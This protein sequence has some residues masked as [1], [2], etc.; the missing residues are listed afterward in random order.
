MSDPKPPLKS[1]RLLDDFSTTD[2][3]DLSDTLS[4]APYP[5]KCIHLQQSLLFLICL[6]LFRRLVKS[7]LANTSFYFL[8]HLSYLTRDL[9]IF[10]NKVG[11]VSHHFFDT[12][13]LVVK[14]FVKSNTFHVTPESFPLLQSFASFFGAEVQSVS[15]EVKGTFNVDMFL[16]YSNIM[17]GLEI[18]LENSSDL[19]F[20]NKSSSLFPRLKELQVHPVD[21]LS[22][23]LK[24]IELLKVNTTV[25]SIIL[26]QISVGAEGVRALAEMLKVN[27]T[28]TH[29]DL[30]YITIGDEG[31]K[32]LADALKVNT[33]VTSI[34]LDDSSIAG[35]G[36]KA[37]AGVSKVNT[38][39]TMTF[40]N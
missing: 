26:D 16:S 12:T 33:A 13:V 15:F 28:L 7:S 20:L 31:A 38:T 6:Q 37:L 3:D 25:T 8:R 22:L 36:I 29:I 23:T 17:T 10:F 21:S 11:Y 39:V 30:C 35:V 4:S 24:L 1:S 19:D 2:N 14:E 27:S 9:M 40:F 5:S 34:F 32:A 18:Y